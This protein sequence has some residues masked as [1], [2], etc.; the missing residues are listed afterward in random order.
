MAQ[1]KKTGGRKAG[2][3]NKTTRDARAAMELAFEGAGGSNALT[4]W[5]KANR[6]E[7]YKLWGRLIPAE[8]KHGGDPE[9]P[10]EHRVQVWKIG[11]REVRF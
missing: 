7:F 3:P 9:K 10:I 1:G 6:T 2:T 5:A 11:D 4:K 8:V